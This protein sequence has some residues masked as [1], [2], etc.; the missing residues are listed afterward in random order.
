MFL[1]F[2]HSGNDAF[3]IRSFVAVIREDGTLEGPGV[4]KVAAHGGDDNDIFDI[5]AQEELFDE[6][7]VAYVINSLVDVD[8]GT[9]SD[10]AII[11]GTEA[12]DSFVVTGGEIFGCG[13]TIKYS[14]IESLDIVALEGNDIISVLSTGPELTTAISGNLGSDTI[15]ITPRNVDPVISKNLRGH[16]GIV[17]HTVISENDSSFDGLLL[18]G[19]AVNVMDNDSFGWINIVEKE[20]LHVLSETSSETFSF[21]IYPTIAPDHNVTVTI[22]AQTDIDENSYFELNQDAS[23]ILTWTFEAGD[24]APLEIKVGHNSGAN[25]LRITDEVLT[26][27][28]SLVVERTFDNRFKDLQQSLLPITAR[29]LPRRDS[30][31]VK[32]VAVVQPSGKMFVV[33]GGDDATYDVYLRPCTGDMKALEVNIEPTVANQVILTP[34]RITDWGADCKVTVNVAAVDDSLEEGLHFVTLAHTLKGPPDRPD[35]LKLSDES[36]LSASNVLVKIYDNELVDVIVDEPRLVTRTAE[37]DDAAKDKISDSSLYEDYYRIRLTKPPNG[38]VTV[39]MASTAVTTDTAAQLAAQ[40]LKDTD[41][42]SERLEPRGQIL[43]ENGAESIDIVFT[44]SNWDTWQKVNVSALNDG[45]TEGANVLHFPSQ[46]SYLSYIQGPLEVSGSTTGVFVPQ[47]ADPLMLPNE[48]ENATFIPPAGVVID[49]SALDAIEENQVDRLLVY[50]LDV[51]GNQPSVGTLTFDQL[52][53]FNMGQGIAIAGIEQR[54]GLVYGNM[55]IVEI[56]LGNGVDIV[57]VLNTSEALHL[58]DLRGGNDDVVVKDISGPFVIQGG[59]GQDSLVVSSDQNKT[60]KINA[61]CMFD[62][63]DSVDSLTLDDSGEDSANDV[64]NVTRLLVELDSMNMPEETML[65]PTD[66]YLVSLRG[67]T[68]GTFDLTLYD[69]INDSNSTVSV[70]YPVDLRALEDALKN[71]LLTDG[72]KSCGNVGETKCSDVVQVYS[73]GD[74][75]GLFFLGERLNS[76]VTMDLTT[77]SLTSYESEQFGDETNDLLKKNSDFAYANVE[78]LTVSTGPFGKVINVRGTT[79]DETKILASEGVDDFVFIASDANENSASAPIVDFLH[80]WLDYIEGNLTIVAGPGRNRLMISDE[81]SSIAKGSAADPMTL[82]RDSLT[83]IKDNLGDI[84]FT[85]DGGDWSRGVNIWLGSNSDILSVL[86]IPSNTEEK[87]RTTTS[88]HAGEGNDDLQV[89]LDEN[90]NVGSVFVANGQGGNDSINATSSSLSVILFGE[91]G[92][93]FLA[94]GSG[95]DIVFGDFGRVYWRNYEQ[96][97]S[98]VAISGGGGYGDLTDGRERNVSDIFS[99]S[100]DDG[101]DDEIRLG[102]GDDVG[103]GGFGK[104]MIFAGA[105]RDIVVSK[106]GLADFHCDSIAIANSSPV[107]LF[108]DNLTVWRFCRNHILAEFGLPEAPTSSFVGL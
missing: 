39:R 21:F 26:I 93:D 95:K 91:D 108:L 90:E 86:S 17:E 100:D 46:P 45:I 51:R 73:L 19:V 66:S 98:I 80:G 11:V 105:D 62:G 57:T 97:A 99:T 33:E 27:T 48:T 6:F 31:E 55:E 4:E 75:L 5:G 1:F 70:D 107:A 94:G 35:L 58:L 69:P 7:P 96:N 15:R 20:A 25:P 79:A 76:G 16:R 87:V 81:K 52:V 78:K 36:T 68:G 63:G 29:L 83:Q 2:L 53:G 101:G 60:D 40:G 103:I 64:L 9:G 34:E 92:V 47:I 84:F 8:G 28:I 50:N 77:D 89:A 85:A 43:F 18:E 106:N 49:L 67:A 59:G 44:S 24:M 56:Y 74:Q 72:P 14:N 38:T 30:T 82:Q 54:D 13:R 104:D 12:D 88:V 42:Q 32:S 41:Y 65:A 3:V 37:L 22:V 10:Q 23:G 102:D 71:E 61:L